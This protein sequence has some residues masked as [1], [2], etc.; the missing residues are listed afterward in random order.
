MHNQVINV[1]TGFDNLT[2]TYHIDVD[3]FFKKIHIVLGLEV[4]SL[5]IGLSQNHQTE[6][7]IYASGGEL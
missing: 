7:S 5:L 6:Y 3:C 4:I 2:K 1:I